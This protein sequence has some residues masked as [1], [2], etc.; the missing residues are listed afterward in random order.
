MYSQFRA[1]KALASR[2]GSSLKSMILFSTIVS[3]LS[4]LAAESNPL[5]NNFA[6]LLTGVFDSSS[7]AIDDSDYLDVTVRHCPINVNNLPRD[8]RSCVKRSPRCTRT[9]NDSGEISI[10]NL[11]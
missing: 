1:N 3:S 4:A 2:V 5:V 9:G 10:H 8:K 11:P 7:Q 6:D